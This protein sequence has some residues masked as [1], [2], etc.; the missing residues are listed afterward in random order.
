MKAVNEV[1][2]FTE[3]LASS[4]EAAA[5]DGKLD[6][7]DAMVMVP[8]ISAGSGFFA[9][10]PGV[11]AEVVGAFRSRDDADLNALF[12]AGKSLV[13]SGKRMYLACTKLKPGK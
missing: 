2:K 3:K 13:T 10:L 8:L 11:G 6:Y 5:A 7:G 9:A 12:E 1:V 4:L